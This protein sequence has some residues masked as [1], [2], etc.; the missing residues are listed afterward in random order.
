MRDTELHIASERFCSYSTDHCADASNATFRLD[1]SNCIILC[2]PDDE[3][4]CA[5]NKNEGLSPHSQVG[6]PFSV[7]QAGDDSRPIAQLAQAT[8]VADVELPFSP[9]ASPD[10]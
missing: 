3:R 1:Q 7:K 6:I 8:Q 2:D 4:H 5:I 9:W 10:T